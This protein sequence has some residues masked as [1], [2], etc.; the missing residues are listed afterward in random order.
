MPSETQTH[1]SLTQH[2]FGMFTPKEQH[3]DSLHGK[4]WTALL[5]THIIN[6]VSLNL[7]HLGSHNLMQERPVIS[8]NGWSLFCMYVKEENELQTAKYTNLPLTSDK[9]EGNEKSMRKK[10][11]WWLTLMIQAIRKWD[12]MSGRKGGRKYD[13]QEMVEEKSMKWEILSS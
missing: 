2:T 9:G 12:K 4:N 7:G 3:T 8:R 6:W 10:V 5:K 1:L 11:S 13:D